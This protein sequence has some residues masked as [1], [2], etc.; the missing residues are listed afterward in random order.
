MSRFP[1]GVT[2][3]TAAD[4]D[5]K[6]VGFTASSFCSVSMDPALVLVCVANKAQCFEVF[7][8]ADKWMVHITTPEHDRLSRLFATRGAD[9]FAGGEF[10]FDE[11]GLPRLGNAA[12][13]LE[14]RTHARYPAG[15]HMILVG[16][17]TATSLNETPPTLYYNRE[18]SS[19]ATPTVVEVN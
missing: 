16:E 6:G 9:K 18:F 5:G 4:R 13:A 14:C 10:T 3:V 15:D 1:S 2:I 7:G 19:V 8:Y 11:S 12:V 17:V